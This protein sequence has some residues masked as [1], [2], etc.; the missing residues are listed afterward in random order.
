MGSGRV[1]VG[2]LPA[3]VVLV[4]M[5]LLAG[6]GDDDSSSSSTTDAGAD[7][8]DTTTTTTP[9]VGEESEVGLED[10]EIADSRV[11]AQFYADTALAWGEV[12]FDLAAMAEATAEVYPTISLVGYASSAD[13]VS[14]SA[15]ANLLDAGDAPGPDNPAVVAFAVQDTGGVCTGVVVYGDPVPETQIDVEVDEGADCNAQAV[16]DAAAD[17]LGGG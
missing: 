2:V 6:C 10:G 7:T 13:P 16:V 5:G 17:Q 9:G 8:A 4:G 14:V 1:R 15:L 12:A 11:I 3:V